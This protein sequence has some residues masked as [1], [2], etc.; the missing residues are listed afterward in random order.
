MNLR[1]L[2][3]A[4][5]L[6]VLVGSGVVAADRTPVQAQVI[7]AQTQGMSNRNLLYVRRRIEGLINQLQNDRHDYGG[8]RVKAI[9]ELQQARQDIIAAIGYQQT[10]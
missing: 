7:V 4:L 5:A 10:H 9:A 1:V 2:G 8:Y 3:G 6:T